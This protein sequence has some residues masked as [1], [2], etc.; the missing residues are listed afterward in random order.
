MAI[1]NFYVKL[2]CVLVAMAV[3]LGLVHQYTKAHEPSVSVTAEEKEKPFSNMDEF[4]EWLS[5]IKHRITD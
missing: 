4:V 3:I 5:D 2:L 1:K